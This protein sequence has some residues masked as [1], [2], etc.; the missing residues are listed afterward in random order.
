MILDTARALQVQALL[1]QQEREAAPRTVEPGSTFCCDEQTSA[2]LARSTILLV[3]DEPANIRMLT[4]M[5]Q[6]AGCVAV[7][8]ATDPADAM[9]QYRESAPD[10]MLL[11]LRMPG[12]DG[13]EV[14][15]ALGDVRADRA[16]HPVLMLTGDD[17]AAAR[18]RALRGGASDFVTKPFEVSEVL[19]RI[20]NLLEIRF[21]Y[22]QQREQ[23]AALERAV[24]ARTAELQIDIARREAVQRE[25]Q[26][27][28][29]RYRHLVE[30]ASDMIFEADAAGLIRYVNQT[31]ADHLGMAAEQLRGLPYLLFVRPDAHGPLRRFYL[32]QKRQRNPL[33]YKEFP[34]VGPDGA[35]R[36]IGLSVRMTFDRQ[37]V[38]SVQAIAR[39]IT[40]RRELERLKDEFIAVASHELR[41]PLTSIRAALNLLN[42][43]LLESRPERARDTIALASRNADRLMHL[44]NEM[45]DLER[46]ESGVEVLDRRPYA[47]SEVLAQAAETVAAA[48]E[49]ADV[50]LIVRPTT[51]TA[52]IDPDR[53]LRVLV[54]LLSNAIKF[55]PRG[56][57]VWIGAET[58]GRDTLLSVRDQGRGIPAA[59]LKSVFGRFAQVRA[60]DARDK[61]GTGLGLAICKSIVQQ[62]G[63]EIWAE[64]REGE[65]STFRIR[66]PR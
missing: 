21:L 23:N 35:E 40:E 2:I 41:S 26:G 50:L 46:L 22:Q 1:Q 15:E 24:L 60:S 10:L 33:S 56:G 16:L 14:L 61:G 47:L 20:R 25:L 7:L 64:S 58:A 12:M 32:K 6:R 27:S 9:R 55:S 30:N 65:G 28:E 66:L 18:Q 4:R 43:G 51:L 29:A 52:F 48:A 57:C 19:L 34:A 42:G 13:A 36:W 38:S 3:D 45:L 59:Q 5:L 53:M 11:D 31:G 44:V 17:S 8:S 63:G 49:A 54:N 39:D 37:G 62:H